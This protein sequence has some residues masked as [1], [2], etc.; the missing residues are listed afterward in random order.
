MLSR[1]PPIRPMI[2]P[3]PP[4]EA[5]NKGRI[6]MIISL[7]ASLRKLTIPKR[8]IFIPTPLK[9]VLFI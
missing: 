8:M 5:M 7:L 1:I 9:A 3:V 4:R 6:G 2:I